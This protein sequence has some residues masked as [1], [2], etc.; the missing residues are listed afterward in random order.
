MSY[1]ALSVV[2]FVAGVLFLCHWLACVWMLVGRLGYDSG[3]P[4]WVT[5]NL[6]SREGRDGEI[7]QDNEVSWFLVRL[8]HPN[9]SLRTCAASRC[10]LHW[11][12]PPAASLQWSGEPT[13]PLCEACPL[14]YR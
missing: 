10:T 12:V 8:S 6:L 7:W 13:Y 1:A 3:R 4:N 2:R 9:P 11:P 14:P 5:H